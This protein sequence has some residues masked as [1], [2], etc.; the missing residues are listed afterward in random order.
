MI[1][2]NVVIAESGYYDGTLGIDFF[3]KQNE[4]IF[5]FNQMVL[6]IK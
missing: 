5:D 6:I 3:R 4:V 2:N 1:V